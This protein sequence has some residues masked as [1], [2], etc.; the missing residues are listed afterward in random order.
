MK[1]LNKSKFIEN[2]GED[3]IY[4]TV[5]EAVGACNYM[6]HTG[7]S[8]PVKDHEVETWNNV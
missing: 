4:L 5:G 8:N 7:K 2:I 6:L 3:W 1:K